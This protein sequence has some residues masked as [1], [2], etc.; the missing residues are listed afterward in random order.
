MSANIKHYDCPDCW[1]YNRT[2]AFK[3]FEK[4]LI[5]LIEK[6]YCL[7]EVKERSNYF[8][9]KLELLIVGNYG[10][11]IEEFRYFFGNEVKAIY[12]DYENN[13]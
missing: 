3:L 13:L 7:G 10:V 8:S 4:N 11:C 2:Y 9:I 12:E 5:A 1:K 6:G